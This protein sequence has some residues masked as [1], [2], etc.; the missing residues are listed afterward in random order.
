LHLS[1]K[2]SDTGKYFD[3]GVLLSEIKRNINE[4]KKL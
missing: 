4:N 2:W 1:C 3:P